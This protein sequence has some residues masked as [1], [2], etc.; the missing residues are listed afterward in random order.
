MND[1]QLFE[2]LRV[3]RESL[4]L[5]I[6]AR[7]FKHS[8]RV[9]DHTRFNH[10]NTYEFTCLDNTQVKIEEHNPTGACKL[11][12]LFVTRNTGETPISTDYIFSTAH[13]KRDLERI[14]NCDIDLFGR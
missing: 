2:L 14:L 12:R 1:N 7:E 4:K 3:T 6:F 11:Y 9:S 13:L 8:S 5:S 10:T